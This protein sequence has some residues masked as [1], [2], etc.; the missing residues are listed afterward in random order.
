VS[1]DS[2]SLGPSIR[3]LECPDTTYLADDFPVFWE[4][5]AG[6]NVWDADGNRYVDLTGAFGV[7]VPGHQAL[8]VGIALRAQAARLVHGMGDVHPS[9]L[10]VQVAERLAAIAPGDLGVTLFG[11]AGFE[12]VEAAIKTATLATGRPGVV[13]FEGAYHGLGYGALAVTWRDDFRAPFAIRAGGQSTMVVRV[14]GSATAARMLLRVHS[15]RWTACSAVPVERTSARCSSNRF[16]VA[17][18]SSCR[19]RASFPGC[20]RSVRAAVCCSSVTRS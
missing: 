16:R 7:A 1:A 2:A 11:N 19:T 12:A 8:R 15:R 14:R 4:R 20:A 5:A 3:T 10:K 9:E 18:V 6:A 17:P 13:A